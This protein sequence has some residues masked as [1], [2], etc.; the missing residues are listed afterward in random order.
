MKTWTI[1]KRIAIS[2]GFIFVLVAALAVISYLMLGGAR[3][4]AN[5]MATDALPGAVAMSDIGERVDQI[6]ISVLRVLL[7]RTPED[8][9]KWEDDIAGQRDE[10]LKLM[11]DYEKTIHLAEDRKNFEELKGLRDKYVADREVLF[12]Y[13]NAGKADDAI[14]YNASNVRPA[15]IAYSAEVNKI[16]Q[17]NMDN[18]VNSS[19]RSDR[20]ITRASWVT[21]I[22]SLAIILIGIAFASVAAF[23]LNRILTRVASSLNET[24]IQVA[25]AASQVSSASQTLAGGTSEQASALEETSASLEEMASM[26]KTNASQTEKCQ[27]WMR[28]TRVVVGNVDKL[29]NE[30]AVSIQET[31]RSSEATGKIVKTIEEIAFQTNILALNAAV[32]AARAGESGMGFA[33]V[34]EEVR[35]L[36]QRCAQAAKETG[37][38]IENA[39]AA[40]TK[41][42][43]LT[44]QTQEAFK[45]NIEIAN[46]VGTAIDEMVGAIR[47]QAQGAAQINNAVGQMDKVTQSNAA[48]AEESAAAAEELNS[49]A[50]LM[51][52]SVAQLMQL[53]DGHAVASERPKHLATSA[54]A[55]ASSQVS[56]NGNGHRT[57][58]LAKSKPAA[59]DAESLAD[60]FRNF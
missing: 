12:G 10:I 8:R 24:A 40:A 44:A 34:A 7:A 54:S 20:A 19:L 29:L 32:E 11:G 30:T 18:A 17:W 3:T 59:R 52:Q 28:E 58:T 41:G 38:L 49:Q 9:K 16:A 26:S 2:F 22:L 4:E 36:A 45:Q 48:N 57:A 15:Y 60:S 39:A 43:E 46:K 33:V 23:D 6:Q 37:V 51:K 21:G 56:H 1:K 53:V 31:K 25:S 27:T 13:C 47:E 14:A 42:N 55:A 35:H 50:E 5:F